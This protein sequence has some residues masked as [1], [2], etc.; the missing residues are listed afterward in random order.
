[1]TWMETEILE[2]SQKIKDAFQENAKKVQDIAALI[3]TRN[4]RKI[5]VA[6]RGSSD[7]SG[8]YFK[9]LCEVAV[10]IPVA[11]AAPSVITVYDGKLDL[12]D[13]LTI[14]ISQSGQA[15]DVLAVLNLAKKQKGLAVSVT[16]A[17]GSPL[18]TAA[19]FHLFLAAG[20]E[21]SVAA[22]KSFVSQMFVLA[23]LVSAIAEDGTLSDEL[24]K[25]PRL[26]EETYRLKYT[27][28]RQTAALTGVSSCYVLGRGFNNAIAHEFALKLQETCYMEA[29]GFATSDF[30]HGPFALVDA[31]TNILLLAPSDKTMKDSL[32]MIAKL[33][34]TGA[35]IIAF[36]DDMNLPVENKILLSRVHEY[37][38]PFLYVLA[39]QM[40]ACD[41]AI[42]K[43][44]DP[45]SPRGLKKVTVT[46]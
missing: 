37:I 14:G 45:D 43:G 19:D 34:K 42:K 44:N 30:H 38:S 23:M 35:R 8:N 1:M 16:N 25:L 39:A 21:K 29:L 26:L 7:N 32:E 12:S 10:G 5:V 22:T 41:L 11:F 28:A 40:F 13:T 6:A 15:E 2:E 36:T 27:I 20:E 3:K 46:R 31:K 9:Y 33:K 17:A 18:A 24:Q 4:I